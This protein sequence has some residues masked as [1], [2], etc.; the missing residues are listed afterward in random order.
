MVLLPET[1]HLGQPRA[2]YLKKLHA[3]QAKLDITYDE[4]LIGATLGELPKGFHHLRAERPVGSGQDCFDR[5]KQAIRT[6]TA[7]AELGLLLE[8]TVPEF[9]VGEVIVFALSMKPA[10]VWTTGAC[11]IVRIV[12]EPRRFGFAYATLPHHP[13]SGEEGFFVS[14]TEDDS[15]VFSVAAFARAQ[16]LPVRLAGPIG[17]IFQRRAIQ[18]YLDGYERFTVGAPTK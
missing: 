10:P 16:S 8:P 11:R 7:Q 9:A 4:S 14:R 5:G 18:I 3:E 6:W 13:E 1:F 2:E 12:D 15:V 17:R